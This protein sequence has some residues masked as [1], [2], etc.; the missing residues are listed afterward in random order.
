MSR[1]QIQE[2]PDRLIESPSFFRNCDGC[3]K[4]V[5]F[6]CCQCNTPEEIQAACE[7][8]ELIV[9]MTGIDPRLALTQ[10]L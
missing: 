2:S 10:D 8:F 3:G 5:L 4:E 7:G 1:A 6:V 9:R